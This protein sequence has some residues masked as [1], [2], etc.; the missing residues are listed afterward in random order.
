MLLV[1]C[2][3]ASAYARIDSRCILRANTPYSGGGST[4]VVSGEV[5]CSGYGIQDTYMDVCSG[6]YNSNG[7]WY[8]VSGSCVGAEED[9]EINF[10]YKY[11]SATNGHEY[12][13]ETYGANYSDGG[14]DALYNSSGYT[15]GCQ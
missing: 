5:D 7:N 2:A 11:L 4:Y 15:C 8:T 12:R 6:V 13:S 9:A 10:Q 1:F 14:R 3:S